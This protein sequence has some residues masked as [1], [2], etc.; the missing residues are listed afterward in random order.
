MEKIYYRQERRCKSKNKYSQIS[1]EIDI[2][3][4]CNCAGVKVGALNGVCRPAPYL[5]VMPESMGLHPWVISL[6]DL[7]FRFSHLLIFGQTWYFCASSFPSRIAPTQKIF[8]AI[9]RIVIA[10]AVVLIPNFKK[11]T[12]RISPQKIHDNMIRL[13]PRIRLFFML[14]KRNM[15]FMRF[16]S[17]NNI[18]VPE[19]N[20]VNN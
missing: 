2:Y 7:Q 1:W 12:T 16:V 20:I 5:F 6:A 14:E 9:N 8:D 17:L 18:N 11:G 13:K 10:V 19:V 3:I 15:S 4:L